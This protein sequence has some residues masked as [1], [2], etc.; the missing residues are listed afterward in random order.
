[1]LPL[2]VDRA[3][4]VPAYRQIC[5]RIVELVEQGV[6]CPGDR[7]PPTRALSSSI[8]LHRSTVVRAYEELRAL[9]YVE[10]RVGSYSTIR[11]R[12]R[13]PS[14]GIYRSVRGRG[15]SSGSAAFDWEAVTVPS[16]AALHA[17]A[18]VRTREAHPPPE[19]VDLDRL[20]ADPSL[21]PDDDLRR[22]LKSVLRR[23]GGPALDY[24]E[25]AGSRPTRRFRESSPLAISAPGL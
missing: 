17:L 22:C 11:R 5:E 23:M 12:E 21:A 8:G 3:K 6:L 7:L 13:P 4:D 19:T 25:T 15:S 14:V 1:M 9:G 16:V 20:A 18:G 10:S 2:S 24:S